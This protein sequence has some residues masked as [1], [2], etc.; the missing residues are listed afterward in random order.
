MRFFIE[1]FFYIDSSSFLSNIQEEY[2]PHTTMKL[3]ESTNTFEEAK[4]ALEDLFRFLSPKAEPDELILLE[5]KERVGHFLTTLRLGTDHPLGNFELVFLRP[6]SQYLFL[7]ESGLLMQMHWSSKN[8][9]RDSED[10]G[11]TK[12]LQVEL[13]T[14]YLN[15]GRNVRKLVGPDTTIFLHNQLL[16]VGYF[17]NQGR[18]ARTILH[19]GIVIEEFEQFHS[20]T[21]CPAVLSL[22]TFLMCCVEEKRSQQ[23]SRDLFERIG[24]TW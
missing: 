22:Q 1:L 9:G 3:T 4:A 7:K 8:Q 19:N 10:T 18:V 20:V 2:D 17:F 23:E 5:T 24:F 21:L 15:T 6:D 12:F 13:W 14:C 16:C 11:Q